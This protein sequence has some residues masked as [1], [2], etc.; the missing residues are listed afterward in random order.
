MLCSFGM[1]TFDCRMVSPEGFNELTTFLFLVYLLSY[2]FHQPTTDEALVGNLNSLS[3]I[4]SSLNLE[5]F[6]HVIW[7]RLQILTLGKN[8]R[9]FNS[10]KRAIFEVNP[11][12]GFPK[13]SGQSYKASTLV[14]YE[15]SISNFLITANFFIRLATGVRFTTATD[16]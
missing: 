13:S 4:Y 3:V 1:W 16:L 12:Q 11:M 8:L 7:S 10:S 6:C 2:S 15:Q 14:N 5:Q 9:Q